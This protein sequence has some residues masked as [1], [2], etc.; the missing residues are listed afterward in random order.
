MITDLVGNAGIVN[1]NVKATV[2]VDKV[3]A[4]G[5]DT[6]VIENV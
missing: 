5:P 3:L 4:D 1:K 6:V 2:F